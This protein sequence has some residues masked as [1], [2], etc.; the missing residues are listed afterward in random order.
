MQATPEAWQE[1]V[2]A[3]APEQ[4]NAWQEHVIMSMAP[5]IPADA[6]D[7][8]PSSSTPSE[9]VEDSS[10][11][12]V[13]PSAAERQASTPHQDSAL[14]EEVSTSQDSETPVADERAWRQ[15]SPDVPSAEA[16]GA[17]VKQNGG[18]AHV[19]SVQDTRYSSFW[20]EP[21]AASQGES[22]R[23]PASEPNLE[24]ME[25][26]V[27][28]NAEE[29]EEAER[30]KLGNDEPEQPL[31]LL[32]EDETDASLVLRDYRSL[33]VVFAPMLF[34]GSDVQGIPEDDNDTMERMLFTVDTTIDEKD[35][36]VVALVFEDPVDAT[37]LLSILAHV[38]GFRDPD[39]VTRRVVPM[40]VD[41]A[42]D[43]A[44]WQGASLLCM[45]KGFQKKAEV[46]AG[47][48]IDGL[49]S[50]IAGARWASLVDAQM[51]S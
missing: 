42:T 36:D 47:K 20:T 38:Q 19:G 11:I 43:A 34:R 5:V 30:L 18:S 24:D 28:A 22:T 3:A 8:S 21:H 37:A 51:V 46:R 15:S 4:L 26:A 14:E 44:D 31:R 23:T 16:D 25:P 40:P 2:T 1:V 13:P 49:L 45:A 17:E 35:P 10:T 6:Y 48:D 27:Y 33:P 12:H 9:I 29:M 41:I 50:R 39:A 7:V 32:S